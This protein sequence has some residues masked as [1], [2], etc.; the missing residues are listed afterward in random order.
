MRKDEEVA[1]DLKYLYKQKFGIMAQTH[2]ALG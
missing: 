2:Q 1:F